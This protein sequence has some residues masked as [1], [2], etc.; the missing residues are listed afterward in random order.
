M[1]IWN[2]LKIYLN[3]NVDFFKNNKLNVAVHIR[4]PSPKDDTRI[5]GTDTPDKY[6][7]DKIKHIRENYNNPLFHIYSGKHK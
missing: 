5:D 3:K 4:R 1:F 2:I 7:L 6:F